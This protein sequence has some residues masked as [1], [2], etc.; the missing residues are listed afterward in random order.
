MKN[1]KIIVFKE[2]IFGLTKTTIKMVKLGGITLLTLLGLIAGLFLDIIMLPFTLLSSIVLTKKDK[3]DY[4]IE[5]LKN[6]NNPTKT[7]R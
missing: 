2:D 3:H 5:K 6:A 1:Y 7:R 4:F